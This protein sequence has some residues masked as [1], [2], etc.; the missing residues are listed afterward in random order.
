LLKNDEK[1]SQQYDLSENSEVDDD[2]DADGADDEII[3]IVGDHSHSIMMNS[4]R[5]YKQQ[6]YF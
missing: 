6:R 5:S 1:R 3:D 2:D 4:V